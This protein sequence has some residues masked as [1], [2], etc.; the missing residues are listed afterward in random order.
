[1]EGGL[2]QGG[3]CPFASLWPLVVAD[4]LQIVFS[5]YQLL[6]AKVNSYLVIF[7]LLRLFS[8]LKQWL[9]EDYKS[10]VHEHVLGPRYR[11]ISCKELQLLETS[12]DTW[13]SSFSRPEKLS[14]D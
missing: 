1:M 12:L 2:W 10:W 6:S 11:G 5:P 7:R 4:R 13:L 9:L 3:K 14:A 8:K